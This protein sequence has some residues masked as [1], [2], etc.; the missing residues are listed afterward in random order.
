[1]TRAGG[2]I[3]DQKSLLSPNIVMDGRTKPQIREI[4]CNLYVFLSYGSHSLNSENG[5]TFILL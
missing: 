3:D 2:Q 1:M 5:R 4:S